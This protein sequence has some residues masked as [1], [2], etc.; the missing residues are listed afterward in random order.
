VPV[1]LQD[2]LPA[3]INFRKI[4]KASLNEEWLQEENTCG[5]ITLYTVSHLY[6]SS[7]QLF[8]LFK[9]TWFLQK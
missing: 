6:A 9:A 7:Y 8:S 1:E 2:E 5:Q 3:I 4:I